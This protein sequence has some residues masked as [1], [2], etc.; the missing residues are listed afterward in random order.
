MFSRIVGVVMVLSVLVGMSDAELSAQEEETFTISVGGSN[1]DSS[2]RENPDAICAPSDG[3][4][5][6]IHLDNGNLVGSCTLE[7]FYSPYGG[8]GAGCGVEGVPFNSTLI[9][10]VDEDSLPVGYVP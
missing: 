9:I 7:L 5:I 4:R 8:V 6:I 1:C 2:P 10:T 3:A